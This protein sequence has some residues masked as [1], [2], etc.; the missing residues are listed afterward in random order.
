MSNEKSRFPF[1]TWYVISKKITVIR[2]CDTF[3]CLF[4]WYG[5][6]IMVVCEAQTIR[7]TVELEGKVNGVLNMKRL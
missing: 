2:Q 7:F 6:V 5:F 4:I 1:V 3:V